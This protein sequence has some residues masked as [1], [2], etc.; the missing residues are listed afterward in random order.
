LKQEGLVNFALRRARQGS[1]LDSLRI[2]YGDVNILSEKPVAGS[3]KIGEILIRDW[4]YEH[5]RDFAQRRVRDPYDGALD[6][7]RMSA[8]P[9]LDARHGAI[10]R[11][12][13]EIKAP[14]WLVV[15]TR[16]GFSLAAEPWLAWVDGNGGIR[17]YL[18]SLLNNPLA[19]TSAA[20]PRRTR[21]PGSRQA[22]SVL[23]LRWPVAVWI[24]RRRAKP[25]IPPLG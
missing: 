12:G 16:Y 7:L 5:A 22:A 25:A 4:V 14:V 21:A 18:V 13:A 20:D 6:D 9:V 24:W 11:V 2:E 17:V 8:Q 19:P 15:P 1:I 10:P 3:F 23:K